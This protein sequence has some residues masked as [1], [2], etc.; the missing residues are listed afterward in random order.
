[1]NYILVV[2]DEE[3]IR[4][5]Y[6]MILR[7]AFPLDVVVAAS[8]NK[9][10]SIIKQR[11][12]PEII[13]SDLRMP[14]GDGH[15]LYQQII[16]N[17]WDIPFVVSSTDAA[18]VRLK[19]PDIHGII[20][21]PNITGSIIGLV[22][23]VVSKHRNPPTYV[24]VRISMLLRTG[25]SDFDLYIKLSESKFVK[26]INAGE[27]FIPADA[28]RFEAKGLQH[29][30]ITLEDA[31]GFLK[32]F[33]KNLAMMITSE[34]KTSD[35]SITSLETFETVERIASSLGWTP[36]VIHAAKHAVNLAVKAVSAEPN[37]VKLFK[38]KLSNP[39]SQYSNHVSMLALLSCGFCHNLGWVS[40]STQMKLG[41]AALMH[42]LVLDEK[43]Y[44]DI[45][46]WNMAA[47]DLNDKSPEVQKY[48]NHPAE[49]AN[50]ILTMKDL[51]A[52]VDQIILQHH[53]M[54]DGTGFPRG[55]ISSRIS[56]MA[57]VFIIV[58]DLI[59]FIEDSANFDE[60]IGLFIKH[61][62]VRYN[63]G[64]FK[65]V[66]DVMKDTVEKTRLSV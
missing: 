17:K 42:D 12:K 2:D 19:F 3:D 58:E 61:R 28:E 52:D 37:L 35:L 29:L 24:P 22:D 15:Y 54:K 44:E 27:A 48:R 25:S 6:E 10:L 14:D 36:A 57:S 62:E 66:F 13:I 20:E 59:N 64:N 11:G 60:K 41:L 45:M 8:G 51:P 47:S 65:K 55:L 26:V 1:M 30:L 46:L 4:D 31:D 40:E 33:E 50:L 5:I 56:P 18:S 21:K 63:S 9:A 53:E 49:A 38:Q 23:S 16:E 39:Q 34:N 7:R 43:K 32:A